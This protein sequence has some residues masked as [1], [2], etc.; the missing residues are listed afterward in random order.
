[1]QRLEKFFL[2]LTW[3]GWL[4]VLINRNTFSVNTNE[5]TCAHFG[6]AGDMFNRAGRLNG[7]RVRSHL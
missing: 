2:V 1:M 7:L 5:L 4:L 3:D 6:W